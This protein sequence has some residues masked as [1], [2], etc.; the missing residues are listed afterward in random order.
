MEKTS[1]GKGGEAVGFQSFRMRVSYMMGNHRFYK[2][3]CLHTRGTAESERLKVT[4]LNLFHPT[5]PPLFQKVGFLMLQ[6]SLSVGESE[7][8]ER[9]GRISAGAK[10]RL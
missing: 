7:G 8:N 5:A 10:K 3:G 1:F 9:K 4:A 2:F 6:H